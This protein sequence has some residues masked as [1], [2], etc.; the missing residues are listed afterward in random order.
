MLT[1][2]ETIT[3]AVNIN[4]KTLE[5]RFNVDV[6]RGTNSL[7][8]RRSARTRVRNCIENFLSPT[9]GSSS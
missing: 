2:V 6:R 9:I 4:A 8:I 5:D 7:K 1:N 3:V